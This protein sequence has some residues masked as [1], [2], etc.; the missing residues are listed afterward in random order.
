MMS[1][2]HDVS[3]IRH[4]EKQVFPG[5]MTLWELLVIPAGLGGGVGGEARAGKPEVGGRTG[6]KDIVTHS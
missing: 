1:E 6:P 4:S 2:G 3:P 5:P